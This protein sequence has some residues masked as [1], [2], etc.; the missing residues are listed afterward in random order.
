MAIKL[1]IDTATGVPATYWIV[2]RAELNV[3]EKKLWFVLH[4]Y[5]SQEAFNGGKEK[6]LERP[7][8]VDAN[9]ESDLFKAV[10]AYIEEEAMAQ[11]DFAAK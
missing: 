2:A 3:I 9:P 6:M 1:S 11:P 8:T 7:F 4:G 5:A 10:F